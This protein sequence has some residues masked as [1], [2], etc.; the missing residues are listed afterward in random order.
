MPRLGRLTVGRVD[1]DAD[2]GRDEDLMRIDQKRASERFENP[3]G[4]PRGILRVNEVR[5]ENR[6]LIAAQPGHGLGGFRLA[7]P[8]NGI[9]L[10]D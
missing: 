3:A 6:E 4:H 7:A 1:R 5:Q 9:A 10:A 8:G 2:A